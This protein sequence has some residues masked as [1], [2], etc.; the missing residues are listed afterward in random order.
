MTKK[1]TH[2]PIW[3]LLFFN[4]ISFYGL[5]QVPNSYSGK[6]KIG[7]YEGKAEYSYRVIGIDTILDGSFKMERSNLE[8]L[9]EKNDNSFLIKGNFRNGQPN[10]DWLFQFGEFYTDSTTQVSGFQYRVN[11]NGTLQ[12]AKGSLSQGKPNGKWKIS[13][14]KIKDSQ[15][16]DT[17][18][19][20]EITFLEGIP[21]QSFTI[22]TPDRTLIGRFLRNGLAHDAWTLYSNDANTLET[23]SFNE[24]WLERVEK[25]RDGSSLSVNIFGKSFS[26]FK[27]IELNEGFVTLL[28]IYANARIWEEGQ[29]SQGINALL[30]ENSTNYKNID[31]ILSELGSPHFLSGFKVKAPYFPLDSTA[32]KQLDTASKLINGASKMSKG[33]LNN[34]RLNLIK[35]SDEEANY[36]YQVVQSLDSTFL[37]PLQRL[38]KLK[39]LGVVENLDGEM[40]LDY[41]FPKGIPSPELVLGDGDG[42]LAPYLG[43]NADS[44]QFAGNG[45]TK[46]LEMAKYVKASLDE[47]SESLGQKLAD[48]Q[49]QQ[50]FVLLEE[51]LIAQTN[52]LNQFPDSI[53]RALDK[54][55]LRA[56]DSIKSNAEQLL[57]GYADMETNNEKLNYARM[58]INCMVHF[59]KLSEEIITL[60]EKSAELQEKYTD[61]VW[62]PFTATIMDETVK[63]RITS[64]YRNVLL[65]HFLEKVE[66]D[67]SC[68]NGEEL[69]LLFSETYQ[70]M[71][72][73]RD[74]DTSKLER[75]LRK[76]RN[77]RVV[78]QL[79]NLKP[80]AE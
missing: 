72:E 32:L 55:A 13:Q 27:V 36:L 44:Y 23:W 18:F 7:T 16:L 19:F 21:Q 80:L 15:V 11:V 71:L 63:K 74:E 37:V 43:P 45:M 24:G 67:L 38:V 10:G 20:S 49:Q 17:L 58:L 3:V 34:T 31:A 22:G 30:L 78:L 50:E 57:S 42:S 40:V 1:I 65:P 59:Q 73:L 62:N 35:R 8:A 61:A 46:Y 12:E 14:K 54:P 9:L 47:I 5:G 4:L 66:S 52:G 29:A 26:R 77:P 76:E 70:R 2:T 68:D 53:R 33:F 41:T 6:F 60:P 64:A 48:D 25:D 56:L 28:R 79:F 51:Q 39:E 75:K 69:H